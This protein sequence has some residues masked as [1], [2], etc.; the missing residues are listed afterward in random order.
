MTIVTPVRVAFFGCGNIAGSYA[1]SMLLHPELTLAGAFDLDEVTREKFAAKHSCTAYASL[2]ELVLG[3]PDIVVN[4][5]P[6]HLHHATTAELLGRGLTVY[7]E[8]PLSLDPGQAH[9][10]VRQA[11]DAAVRLA[12]APSLWLGPT[13]MAAATAL[14]DG[15]VGPVRLMTAEVSQGRIESW[16][17]A[18][19]AFYLVGP[20]VDVAVYPLAYLTALFGPI[21][22]VT[23]ISTTALKDRKTLDGRPFSPVVADTWLVSARFA[24]GPLLRLSCNFFVASETVPRS[25]DF[26]GDGG[27]LRL[28]DWLL[29]GAEILH[30][31]AGGPFTVHTP[32]DPTLALDWSLG[33][34]DL[35]RSL[36]EDRPHR[37]GAEHA[38]HIVDVLGAVAGSAGS[39]RTVEVTSTFPAPHGVPQLA[40]VAAR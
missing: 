30:A 7:S 31:E 4:L 24:A 21:S 11:A 19:E 6:A 1:V 15:V 23:A 26:H 16:H 29:P 8:K 35:A 2:D 9:G 25:L 37:N 18:P 27:S 39:G 12:C 20:V 40:G 14:D 33:L 34:L 13:T 10:L 32:A 22:E 17:P 36:Q 3:R 38:A 28:T 5:T